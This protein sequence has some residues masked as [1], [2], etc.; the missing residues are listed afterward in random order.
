MICG[1]QRRAGRGR[2]LGEFLGAV[3]GVQPRVIA[4]A[5]ALGEVRL[6]P[7]VGRVLDQ[8]LDRKQRDVDL[9]AHLQQIT[10]VHENHR[11]VGKHDRGAGRAGEA[12]EPREPLFG[13]RHVLVL[14]PVGARDDET[15]EPAPFQFGAHSRDTAGAR[16]ALASIIERLKARLEHRRNLLSA[17]RC[18][19]RGAWFSRI[20][21]LCV[22]RTI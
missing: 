12:G 15:V 7:L 4:E 20:G 11:A 10:P 2:G 16:G 18:G 22:Q 14:M 8:M 3:G 17:F 5:R 1:G 13:G 19:N 6:Q 9:V 21:H